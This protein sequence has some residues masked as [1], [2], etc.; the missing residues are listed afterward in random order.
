MPDMKPKRATLLRN[1]KVARIDLVD[2]GASYDAATG[3]GAHVLLM[4]RADATTEQAE[5]SYSG[6]GGTWEE[7]QDTLRV[8]AQKKLGVANDGWVTIV[9]TYDDAVVVER[10]EKGERK[11]YK[12]A[13]SIA[14]GGGVELGEP[15]EVGLRQTIVDADA[16]L[17]G[18]L[19]AMLAMVSSG[20]LSKRSDGQILEAGRMKLFIDVYKI[21]ARLIGDAP[22]RRDMITKQDAVKKLESVEGGGEI[23]A[24]IDELEKKASAAPP[25]VEDVMKAMPPE[26]RERV[27]KA[28]ASAAAAQAIAKRLEDASALRDE[29][30]VCKQFTGLGIDPKF[31]DQLVV[32]KRANAATYDAVIVALKAANAASKLTKTVGSDAGEGPE[33]DALVELEKKA[34]A[35]VAT[36]AC[37]TM[38][39][40]IEK[41]AKDEPALYERYQQETRRV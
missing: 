8:A 25:A 10:Y 41:A 39:E 31:P 30:E 11:C 20:K 16:S 18:S 29:Q 24:L 32:L 37:K 12:L 23:V 36:G 19:R 1:L 5:K 14:E 17:A 9:G 28:E 13:W 33:S 22:G 27:E 35:L 7:I 21:L 2:R 26:V 6:L 40:A 34:A 15:V 3:L 38:P 4:K